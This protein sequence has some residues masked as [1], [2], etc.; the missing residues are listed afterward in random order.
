MK[1]GVYDTWNQRFDREKLNL[2][3]K[4]VYINAHDCSHTIW[5]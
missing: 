1:S 4:K 5:R 2:D 3:T